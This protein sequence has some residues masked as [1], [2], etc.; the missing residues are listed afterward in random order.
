MIGRV[1]IFLKTAVSRHGVCDCQQSSIHGN[2]G[3]R[4][5]VELD[6]DTV[7]TFSVD[8]KRSGVFLVGVHGSEFDNGFVQID[9]NERSEVDAGYTLAFHDT[10]TLF[11]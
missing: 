2:F 4:K 11:C 5:A 10:F 8:N 6:F 7:G 1:G 9:S 3:L